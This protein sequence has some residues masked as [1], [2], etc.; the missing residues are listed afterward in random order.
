MSQL[1]EVPSI[2]SPTEIVDALTRLSNTFSRMH[3]A[4]EDLAKQMDALRTQLHRDTDYT[5]YEEP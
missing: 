3:R 4:S 5:I 2:G 1:R